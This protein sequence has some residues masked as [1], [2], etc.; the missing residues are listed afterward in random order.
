M[1]IP[2]KSRKIKETQQVAAAWISSSI[3]TINTEYITT[4]ITNKSYCQAC[5][6]SYET[7]TY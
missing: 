2:L 7:V 1:K 5:I 6:A 3:N 4:L